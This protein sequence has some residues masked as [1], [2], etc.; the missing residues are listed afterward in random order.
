MIENYNFETLKDPDRRK[1]AIEAFRLGMCDALCHLQR[2][3][4]RSWE[5]YGMNYLLKTEYGLDKVFTEHGEES[6]NDVYLEIRALEEKVM[7]ILLCTSDYK[8]KKDE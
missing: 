6:L 7:K 5:S 2:A 4:Q 1:F 8:E 3:G